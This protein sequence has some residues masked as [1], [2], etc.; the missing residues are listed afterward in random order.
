M[1]DANRLTNRF[2]QMTLPLEPVRLSQQLSSSAAQPAAHHSGNE[3]QSEPLS[4]PREQA[5]LGWLV[6][7]LDDRLAS[8]EAR[9]AQPVQFAP[10]Q[11]E[12]PVQPLQKGLWGWMQGLSGAEKLALA[13]LV[14]FVVVQVVRYT[15]RGADGGGRSSGKGIVAGLGEYAGRKLVDQFLKV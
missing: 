11:P 14:G 1:T 7:R 12:Q 9:V 5:Q 3:A 6:E 15:S 4:Q 13:L 8:I 2:G 10:I